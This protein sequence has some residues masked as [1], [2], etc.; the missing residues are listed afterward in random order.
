MITAKVLFHVNREDINH[1]NDPVYEY[2]PLPDDLERMY[3]EAQAEWDDMR[4]QYIRNKM[5][6]HE[7]TEPLRIGG[8]KELELSI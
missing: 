8:F 7:R 5:L 3:R 6:K 4:E 1:Q 2:G